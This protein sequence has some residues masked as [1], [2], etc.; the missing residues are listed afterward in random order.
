MDIFVITS[1][2]NTGNNRWSYTDIRSCYTP[3]ERLAQ[4]IQTIE[5]IRNIHCKVLLVECSNID[6]QTENILKSKVDYYLQT[7]HDADVRMACLESDKKGFGE[8]K[9]LEKACEYIKNNNIIFNKLFKISGRYYLNSLFDVKKYSDD[10]FTFKIFSTSGSTVL[11]SV[12]YSRFDFYIKMLEECSNIY[13]NGPIGLETI[14]PNLC[15]PRQEIQTL[16]VSGFVAVL[17]NDFYTA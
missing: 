2:I 13:I 17:N 11:Y 8:I 5:S 3:E 7:Y 16:G 9:K 4:T 12:P 15:V 10:I 1:V 6:E 14:L